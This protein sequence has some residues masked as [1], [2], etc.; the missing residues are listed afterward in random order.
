MQL[1][2]GRLEMLGWRWTGVDVKF[3]SRLDNRGEPR[4]GSANKAP[5]S[6]VKGFRGLFTFKSL[7][8]QFGIDGDLLHQ[9]IEIYQRPVQRVQRNVCRFCVCL[10]CLLLQLQD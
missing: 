9:G 10:F 2:Y 8:R 7:S 5:K 3:G 1:S 6:G 4:F